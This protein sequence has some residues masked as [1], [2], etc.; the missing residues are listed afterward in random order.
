[1]GFNSQLKPTYSSSLEGYRTMLL[2]TRSSLLSRILGR[3]ISIF[4]ILATYAYQE[5]LNECII[6][7]SKYVIQYLSAL[8]I[9]MVT[10]FLP[11]SDSY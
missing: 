3:Q 11:A 4:S 6:L 8:C 10:T 2:S 9:I 7:M 5:I 1:M